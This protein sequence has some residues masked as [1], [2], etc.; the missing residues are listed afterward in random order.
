MRRRSSTWT[1][2]FGKDGQTGKQR[3]VRV[4]AVVGRL[5]Y[6]PAAASAVT[7]AWDVLVYSEQKPA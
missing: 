3:Q 6:Q 7:R 5:H 2:R 4:D 1:K